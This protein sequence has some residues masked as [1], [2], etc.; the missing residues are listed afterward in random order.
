MLQTMLN[1]QNNVPMQR[2]CRIANANDA[3][4]QY[5]GYSRSYILL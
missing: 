5:F 4:L 1:K 2:G 3:K